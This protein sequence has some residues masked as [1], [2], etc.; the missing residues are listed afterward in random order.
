MNELLNLNRIGKGVHKKWIYPNKDYYELGCDYLQKINFC[1]Q[2]FNTEFNKTNEINIKSVTYL[3]L[4]VTWIQEAYEQ[5]ERIFDDSIKSGFVYCKESRLSECKKYL[6]A[7]RSFVVA[8]PLSTNQHKKYLLEGNYICVDIS[9][10]LSAVQKL[11]QRPFYVFNIEGVEQVADE[12]IGRECD[13]YLLVYSKKDGA[14]FF[15]Y[16]GCRFADLVEIASLYIDKLYALDKH[17]SKLKR[18][19]FC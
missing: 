6:R 11:Q 7:L 19:D 17:L 16:F 15:Q 8:H 10:R 13:Y 12:K 18:T 2:D 1:I 3:I 5:F 9:V 14:R 4:L